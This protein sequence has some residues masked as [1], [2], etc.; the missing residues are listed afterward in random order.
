[1]QSTINIHV[2]F[3]SSWRVVHFYDA[4]SFFS[5][6]LSVK[7]LPFSARSFPTSLFIHLQT[8]FFVGARKTMLGQKGILNY[9]PGNEDLKE[10]LFVN[11]KFYEVPSDLVR[12]FAL[13]FA[14]KYPG[15]LSEAIQDL[16]RKAVKESS[17]SPT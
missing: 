15:G 4:A 11:I 2:E 9:L 7:S 1:M 3:S 17:S 5:R 6:S 13:K 10:D 14:Y 12:E 16:M 8:A